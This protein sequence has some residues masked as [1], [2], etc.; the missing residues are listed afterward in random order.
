MSVR[1]YTKNCGWRIG[2]AHKVVLNLRTKAWGDGFAFRARVSRI[3][4]ARTCAICQPKY[5]KFSMEALPLKKFLHAALSPCAVAL[6]MGPPLALA[7][8]SVS[9]SDSES[10]HHW[11]VELQG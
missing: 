3:P 4:P 1:S 8:E 7:Q 5:Q 11:F 9:V 6:A 10:S 2:H